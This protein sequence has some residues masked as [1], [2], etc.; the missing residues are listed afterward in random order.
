VKNVAPEQKGERGYG[1]AYTW[2]AID[3]DTKMMVSY[4]VGKR[5]TGYA[6]LFMQGLAERIT[7]RV[8]L[9]TVG[10]KPYLQNVENSFGGVWIMRRSLGPMA[11]QALAI[12]AAT[13]LRNS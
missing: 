2:T 9:T 13:A 6:N 3:A 5:D 10:P 11:L 12:S 8:Q 4:M 1:D 7:N